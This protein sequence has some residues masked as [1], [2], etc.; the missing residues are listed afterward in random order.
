MA[1]SEKTDEATV[2]EEVKTD[3]QQVEGQEKG[4][5]EG[6][7]ESKGDETPETVPYERFQEVVNKVEQ[8]EKQAE[9]SAQQM[10][11]AKANPPQLKAGPGEQFDIFKEVGAVDDEDMLTVAQHRKVLN[12]Y[13]TI[14]DRRL[15]EIDFRQTRPD[16][17]DLVGTADEIAS[18]KYAAPLASAIKDNPALE[19]LISTSGNPRVAAYEI[20]KLQAAKKSDKK[21]IETDEAKEAIDEAVDNAKR[22][23]SSSNTKGGG[24]LSEEG[25]YAKMPNADFLKLARSHGAI[26]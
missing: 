19:K 7:E 13:G 10:A 3:E 20:A 9:V 12:H 11:I 1:D 6:Q 17:A 15:A 5:V 25:R 26:V 14:F 24:A 18:G 23:K 8:L 21:P 22:I 2:E 4:T 16:Y